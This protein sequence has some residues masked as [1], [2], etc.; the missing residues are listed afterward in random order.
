[1]WLRVLYTFAGEAWFCWHWVQ[2][3]TLFS[4]SLSIPGHH[5]TLLAIPLI[6]MIPG[7]PSCNSSITLLLSAGGN[8]TLLPHRMQSSSTESSI[9]CRLYRTISSCTPMSLGQ[10][11]QMNSLTRDTTRS[12]FAGTGTVAGV[13]GNGSQLRLSALAC[14]DPGLDY[15]MV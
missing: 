7:W 2:V 6:L 10:P 4:R 8:T 5:K 11:W 14:C 3:L 1:M 12:Q 15:S 13:S 9:F